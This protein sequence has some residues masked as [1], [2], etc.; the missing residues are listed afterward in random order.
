MSRS[1]ARWLAALLALALLA[2]ACGD[3]D[4]ESAV[5]TLEKWWDVAMAA[6]LEAG[7]SISR[8]RSS[9]IR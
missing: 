5:A 6:C 1:L 8:T 7:G 4:D 3:D 2:T 9:R